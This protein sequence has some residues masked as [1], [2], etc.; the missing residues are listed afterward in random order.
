MASE[1]ITMEC[2]RCRTRVRSTV[3]SHEWCGGCRCWMRRVAEPRPHPTPDQAQAIA[4][5]YG[6][7][8]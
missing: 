7:R 1:T 3:T 5:R 6:E 8:L 2:P 4:G